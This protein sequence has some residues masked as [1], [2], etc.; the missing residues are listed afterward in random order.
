MSETRIQQTGEPAVVEASDGRLTLSVPIRIKRRSGRK[1]VTL[2]TG[3]ALPARP[4][5]TAPT[6]VQLALARGHRWLAMLTSREV[7]SLSEI[8]ARERELQL[9]QPYGQ[10]DHP[11]AGHHRPH[12]GRR[13][14]RPRHAAR[15]GDQS[16]AV[17]GG[18]AEAVYHALGCC[19]WSPVSAAGRLRPTAD[20]HLVAQ[21]GSSTME[22]GHH[23]RPAH[24]DD[25]SSRDSSVWPQSLRADLWKQ[26]AMSGLR[27]LSRESSETG[28]ARG[29]GGGTGGKGLLS[30]Q[31]S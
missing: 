18:A 24:R 11:C 27:C 28:G 3:E 25:K 10:P 2:P 9:R 12:P 20:T 5:N 29:T 19:G 22:I 14:S 16:A 17:V 15:S 7:K 23:G 4:W 31:K 26:C 30:R 1:L 8:A 13:R 21:R 6:A